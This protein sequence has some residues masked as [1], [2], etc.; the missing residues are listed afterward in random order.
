MQ[1]GEIVF[2]FLAALAIVVTVFSVL[3]AIRL[4]RTSFK[5]RDLDMPRYRFLHK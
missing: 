3:R 4:L 5:Q 2:V 1:V